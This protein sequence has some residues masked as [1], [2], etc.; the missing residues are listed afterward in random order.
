VQDGLD[1]VPWAIDGFIGPMVPA[2]EKAPGGA[3]SIQRSTSETFDAVLQLSRC[4]PWMGLAKG[5]SREIEKLLFITPLAS[6]D[7]GCIYQRSDS[8]GLTR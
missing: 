3:R 4:S 7:L 5:V 2:T 1:I 6:V 8:S